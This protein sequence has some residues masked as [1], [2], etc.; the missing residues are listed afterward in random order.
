M[1]VSEWPGTARRTAP[2]LAPSRPC[3][4]CYWAD[5]EKGAWCR[6]EAPQPAYARHPLSMAWD[7]LAKPLSQ[8]PPRAM[9]IGSRR[10]LVVR[11]PGRLILQLL[12]E[13]LAEPTF[14]L[15]PHCT[16][17]PLKPYQAGLSTLLPSPSKL[18]MIRLFPPSRPISGTPGA[19]GSSSSL[20]QSSTAQTSREPNPGSTV[21]TFR[22]YVQAST[23]S[24]PTWGRR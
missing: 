13:K 22:W 3:I 23:C 17:K 20:S 1:G 21:A 14:V 12:G 7:Y 15:G 4:V 19:L 2:A 10:V 18:S 8:E 6:R 16:R 9:G 24:T 5:V 11:Y